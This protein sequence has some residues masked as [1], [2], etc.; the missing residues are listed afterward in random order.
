MRDNLVENLN[1]QLRFPDMPVNIGLPTCC[2]ASASR[3]TDRLR[4]SDMQSNQLNSPVPNLVL[5]RLKKNIPLNLGAQMRKRI[6]KEQQL[7]FIP[8]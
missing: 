2:S 6:K 4:L 7:N 8:K 3:N 1:C 5:K